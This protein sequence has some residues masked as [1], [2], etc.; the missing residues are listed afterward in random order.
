VHGPS[1]TL[2]K[3]LTL[4]E[5]EAGYDNVEMTSALENNLDHHVENVPGVW[6]IV[7]MNGI[8]TLTCE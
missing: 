4:V 1:A 8:E 2:I 7:R 3:L 6:V 5:I